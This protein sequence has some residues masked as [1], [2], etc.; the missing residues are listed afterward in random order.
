MQAFN[1]DMPYDQF[2]KAQIAGGSDAGHPARDLAG[3]RILRRRARGIYDDRA[4]A[5]DAADERD[6]RVDAVTRGFL[7]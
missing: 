7:G 6:D 1:A 5:T 3:T 2:V 4:L